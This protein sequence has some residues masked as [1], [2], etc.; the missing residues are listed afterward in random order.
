MGKFEHAISLS[1]VEVEFQ[2]SPST[3]LSV[4]F[5][6]VTRK[7]IYTNLINSKVKKVLTPFDIQIYKLQC[8]THMLKNCINFEKDSIAKKKKETRMRL[9]NKLFESK[10]RLKRSE[11][12]IK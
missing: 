4:A 11:V 5:R 9:F 3:P 2:G 7:N 10:S 12:N 8:A 6:D 1:G